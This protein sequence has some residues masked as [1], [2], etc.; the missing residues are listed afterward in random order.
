MA[1]YYGIQRSNDYLAHYGIKGMKWGVRKAIENK[2][3]VLLKE[4]HD[5]ALDKLER[6]KRKANIVAQKDERREGLKSLGLGAALLGS[7]AAVDI[8]DSNAKKAGKDIRWG[9]APVYN[10]RLAVLP[11]RTFSTGAGLIGGLTTGIGAVDTIGAHKRMSQKGHAKAV[12]KVNEWQN[13]MYEA[14]KGTPYETKKPKAFVDKYSVTVYSN[15]GKKRKNLATISG[16]HLARNY[17]GKDKE[18]FLNTARSHPV[19]YIER[20]T[21][22]DNVTTTKDYLR[23]KPKKRK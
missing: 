22:P 17:K 4:H 19:S 20:H 5:L 3:K 14:F 12:Q 23:L 16:D 7:A 21:D 1:K 6:L 15:D 8:I 9:V 2:D 13:E 18:H 11:L 10:P